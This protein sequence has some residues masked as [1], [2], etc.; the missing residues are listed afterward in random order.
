MSSAKRR[1]VRD[2]GWC[3]GRETDREDLP[4]RLEPYPEKKDDEALKLMHSAAD[5]EDTTDKHPSH[6]DPL[7]RRARCW[8]DLL[9]E[10]RQPAEA[11]FERSLHAAPHRFGGLL[12][13]ARSAKI[14]GNAEKA[15]ALYAKLAT[16]CTLAD[17]RR[18]GIREAK[19]GF[20]RMR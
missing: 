19:A 12:G 9:L 14:S 4:S 16:N 7:C 18:D 17:G 11:Q 2:C 3:A 13:A 1:K 15:G 6:L 20:H 8:A 10:L 5:L